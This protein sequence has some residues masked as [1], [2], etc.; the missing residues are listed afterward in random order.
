MA[1][2]REFSMMKLLL[3]KETR[4]RGGEPLISLMCGVPTLTLGLGAILLHLSYLVGQPI[5]SPEFYT[6]ELVGVFATDPMGRS[7]AANPATYFVP[8][9]LMLGVLFVGA[10]CGGLGIHL[11]RR[12]WR[13]RPVTTSAAGMIACA[14]AF[15]LAWLLFVRV[16]LA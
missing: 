7:F 6:V 15:A 10:C 1:G 16:A 13:H 8:S 9:M 4:E 11:S 5:G 3:T 14:A 12:R 2:T